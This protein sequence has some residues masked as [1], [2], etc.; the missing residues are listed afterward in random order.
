M[1]QKGKARLRRAALSGD[2]SYFS[3]V[4]TSL[5]EEGA[6]LC[7]SRAFVC[8]FCMCFFFPFSLP[9]GV[10]SWLWFVIVVLP[11]LFY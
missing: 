7:V 11:G 1:L 8:L 4:I 2:R 5:A 6:G 9:L 3:I 10:G